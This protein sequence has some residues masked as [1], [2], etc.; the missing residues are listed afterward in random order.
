MLSGFD[1]EL[2]IVFNSLGII[3]AQWNWSEIICLRVKTLKTTIE[4]IIKFNL[5]N[6]LNNVIHVNQN[7]ESLT[8]FLLFRKH[9]DFCEYYYINWMN[10]GF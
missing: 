9:S 6:N 10:I 3:P 1:S 7:Y 4:F 2:L 8:R 5:L